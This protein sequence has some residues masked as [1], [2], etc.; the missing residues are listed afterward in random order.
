MLSH[1]QREEHRPWKHSVSILLVHRLL[2]NLAV[3]RLWKWNWNGQRKT[4]QTNYAAER[5]QIC[6]SYHNS[7]STDDDVRS[8]QVLLKQISA[9]YLS[10]GGGYYML[11]MITLRRAQLTEGILLATSRAFCLAVSTAYSWGVL[12]LLL[13]RVSLNQDGTTS[14]RK[15]WYVEE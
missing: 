6:S 7:V 2:Q 15:P 10:F 4:Q 3:D 5:Q 11:F 8:L 14:N 1:I 13:S 9:Q 12:N